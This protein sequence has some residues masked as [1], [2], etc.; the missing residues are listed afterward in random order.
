MAWPDD[1]RQ[2]RRLE[3]GRV[4]TGAAMVPGSLLVEVA[5]A[6]LCP[7]ARLSA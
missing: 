4:M 7:G 5:V 3:H 1:E 6:D 2:E